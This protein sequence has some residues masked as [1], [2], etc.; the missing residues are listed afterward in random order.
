MASMANAAANSPGLSCYTAPGVVFS[1]TEELREHYR[2]DW[3]RYNLKRKVAGFPPVKLEA[4]QKRRAAAM[5]LAEQTHSPVL[6][7]DHLKNKNPKAKKRNGKLPGKGRD[8]KTVNQATGLKSNSSA[9]L[10]TTPPSI[11]IDLDKLTMEEME[12]KAS[13]NYSIFDAQQFS[14]VEDNLKHMNEKYC[15]RIPDAK[16]VSDVQGLIKYCVAKVHLGRI[17]IYCNKAF[18][19]TQG[20]KMHMR[21]MAHCRLPISDEEMFYEEYGEFYDFTEANAE[22]EAAGGPTKFEVLDTGELLLL[23]KEGKPSKII[24]TREFRHVYKQNFKPDDNRAS[25]QAARKDAKER[26]LLMYGQSGI[27]VRTSAPTTLSAFV[28]YQERG[29]QLKLIHKQQQRSMKFNMRVD[30]NSNL[31]MKNDVAGRIKGGIGSGVHG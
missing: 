20:C 12:Q 6:K 9:A 29:K 2:S 26:L 19:S 18:S 7:T 8:R 15:F 21:E 27:S 31:L 14:S 17:C 11:A 13:P 23:G 4:F 1:S 10:S 28:R 22:I 5:R 30:R 16:Y 24:G 3:H 25:V